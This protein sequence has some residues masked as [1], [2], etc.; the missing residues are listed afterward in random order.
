MNVVDEDDNHSVNSDFSIVSNETELP[1]GHPPPPF[2]NQFTHQQEE[3]FEGVIDTFFDNLESSE[4][5]EAYF[6]DYKFNELPSI[7][8]LIGVAGNAAWMVAWI[9][10]I[11]DLWHQSQEWGV[12]VPAG[13]RPSPAYIW[14]RQSHEFPPPPEN[15]LLPHFDGDLDAEE[16]EEV[17]PDEEDDPEMIALM[18]GGGYMP[19]RFY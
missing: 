3:V 14:E 19:H 7:D 11:D 1:E 10:Y 15:W 18:N 12:N 4:D 16:E 6:D 17:D 13:V 8:M 5:W 2:H 9:E